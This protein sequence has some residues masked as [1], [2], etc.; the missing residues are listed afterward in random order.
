LLEGVLVRMVQVSVG[1]GA[2][3]PKFTRRVAKDGS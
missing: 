1:V 3:A 2:G